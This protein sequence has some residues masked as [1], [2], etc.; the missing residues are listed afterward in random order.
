MS[1][2]TE[3]PK[4][5]TEAEVR[6][7]YAEFLKHVTECSTCGRGEGHCEAGGGMRDAWRI[8]RLAAVRQ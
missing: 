3:G 4:P 2:V 5:V 7:L 1:D 6:N 8:A